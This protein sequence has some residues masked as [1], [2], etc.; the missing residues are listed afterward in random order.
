MTPHQPTPELDIAAR[1]PRFN[2]SFTDS[3]DHALRDNA[4]MRGLCSK[5]VVRAA[6]WI[7]HPVQRAKIR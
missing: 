4:Y 1:V 2:I 6:L 3:C 7:Q 5:A